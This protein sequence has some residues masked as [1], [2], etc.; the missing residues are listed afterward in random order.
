MEARKGEIISKSEFL[1]HGSYAK[2]QYEGLLVSSDARQGCYNIGVQLD[3]DKVLIVD[4]AHDNDVRERI[5]NWSSQIE[6]IQ[7]KHGAKA[8]LQNYSKS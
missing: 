2:E 7:R 3:E 5:L 4:H 8:D 1:S 6:D